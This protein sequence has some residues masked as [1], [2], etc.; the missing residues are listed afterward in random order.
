M[1]DRTDIESNDNIGLIAQ[2]VESV[3]PELVSESDGVK[4]LAYSN[5]VAVLVESVK[6]QQK[7]IDALREEI[8]NLK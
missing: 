7:Q 5:M 6:D 2:E 3:I 1:Y 4:S 8:R